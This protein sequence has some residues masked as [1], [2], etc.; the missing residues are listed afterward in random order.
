ML[1]LRVHHYLSLEHTGTVARDGPRPV[2][3]WPVAR[4]RVPEPPWEMMLDPN[5]RRSG[6][7]AGVLPPSTF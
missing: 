4:S 5:R 1:L 3:P 7:T 6:W 2:Q